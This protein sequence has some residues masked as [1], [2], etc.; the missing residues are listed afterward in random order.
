LSSKEGDHGPPSFANHNHQP[1]RDSSYEWVRNRGQ[2][3]CMNYLLH[4]ASG[5][6]IEC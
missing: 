3:S 1:N 5:G 6:E 4:G 2:V